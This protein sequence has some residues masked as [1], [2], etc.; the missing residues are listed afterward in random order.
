MPRGKTSKHPATDRAFEALG[1]QDMWQSSRV[2]NESP[3]CGEVLVYPRPAGSPTYP[4]L[5][6]ADVVSHMFYMEIPVRS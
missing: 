2:Y 5:T 1:E 3:V 6:I 4:P